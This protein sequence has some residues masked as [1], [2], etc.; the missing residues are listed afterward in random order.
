MERVRI[1]VYR[2]IEALVRRGAKRL[3]VGE[4]P[5]EEIQRALEAGDWEILLKG[6]ESVPGG[7][8]MGNGYM[9]EFEGVRRDRSGDRW[10][11][12]FLSVV[13]MAWIVFMGL[14]AA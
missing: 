14:Y 10:V 3:W 7:C 4:R 2:V 5:I 9:T 11:L 1:N 12:L 6:E 13:V 8:E